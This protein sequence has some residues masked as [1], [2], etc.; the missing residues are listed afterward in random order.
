M[1]YIKPQIVTTRP[2]VSAIQS[3]KTGPVIDN[4]DPTQLSG[5]AAYQA[6]E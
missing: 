6:D 1:R 2:A 4:N 3:F 5:G